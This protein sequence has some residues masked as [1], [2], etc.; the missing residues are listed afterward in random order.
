MNSFDFSYVDSLP[1][2]RVGLA[3]MTL[4]PVPES[5]ARPALV[6]VHGSMQGAWCYSHWLK[7]A[8]E[9][10]I[11]ATAVDVRGH[12]GLPSEDLLTAGLDDYGDD[13][14]A[15]ARTFEHPPVLVGHSMGGVMVGVA[16]SRTPVAGLVLLAPSPPAN[17]PGAQPVPPVDESRALPPADEK[18]VREKYLPNHGGHDITEMVKRQCPE[19]SVAAN[20]RYKLRVSVDVEKISCPALCIAAGRDWPITHPPGQDTAV[21]DFYG[22]ENVTL[23]EA[24]HGLMIDVDWR[25]GIDCILEWY[26]RVIVKPAA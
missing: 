24:A 10:G 14:A 13:V 2:K 20:D 12:G 9:A 17:L 15:I 21:G 22:A 23:P 16:A 1:T 8:H 4:S 26:N 3:R 25:P 7:V 5:N 19:S 6:F 11:A 18:T